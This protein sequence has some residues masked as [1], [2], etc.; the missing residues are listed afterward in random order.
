MLQKPL[1]NH[2]LGNGHYNSEA[3]GA[4]RQREFAFYMPMEPLPPAPSFLPL[5][6]FYVWE[7]IYFYLCKPLLFGCPFLSS[8]LNFL[9]C[10][11]KHEK[12]QLSKKIEQNKKKSRLLERQTEF[13]EMTATIVD[14]NVPV[15]EFDRLKAKTSKNIE[16]YS[17]LT[18]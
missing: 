1:C 2:N 18:Y 5:D 11:Y 12:I 14:L 16:D 8:Q 7:K 9:W 13:D 17:N 10:R 15:S 4:E 3:G 6:I